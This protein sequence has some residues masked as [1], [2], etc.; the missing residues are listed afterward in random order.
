MKEQVIMT[1]DDFR[2]ITGIEGD[3]ISNEEVAIIISQLDTLAGV[4]LNQFRTQEGATQEAVPNS[5]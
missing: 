5:L 1:V 2:K 3:Q 4:Y